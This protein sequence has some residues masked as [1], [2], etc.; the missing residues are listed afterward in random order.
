MK[1]TIATLML[2]GA[3][4]FVNAQATRPDEPTGSSANPPAYQDKNGKVTEVDKGTTGHH[5]AKSGSTTETDRKEHTHSKTKD[6]SN[7]S[8]NKTDGNT[9][10]DA[11]TPKQ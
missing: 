11:T 4:Y 3:F 6:Q 10:M 7:S 1:K 2:S 9:N 8:K 5:N